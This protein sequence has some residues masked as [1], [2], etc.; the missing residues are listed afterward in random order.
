MRRADRTHPTCHRGA[1]GSR[2][3]GVQTAISGRRHVMNQR[4]HSDPLSVLN[5]DDL[6]AQPDSSFAARLRQRLESALSLPEGV[7]MSGTAAAIAELTE[8]P[9]VPRPAALPYLSVANARAAITWYVDVF[10]AVVV[11][12]PIVMDDGRIGHAELSMAGGVL[13]LAD[14]H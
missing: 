4:D 14:E 12:D 6:P 9:Q 10:G 7:V 13:Y 3:A 11:G 1:I 5:T 8:P 2:P